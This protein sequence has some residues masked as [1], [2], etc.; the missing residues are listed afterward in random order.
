MSKEPT[1][2]TAIQLINWITDRAINGIPPLCSAENLALVIKIDASYPD[3][4]E[5]IEALINWETYKNFTTGFITGLRK[6][7][8]RSRSQF[9][10]LSEHHG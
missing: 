2:N 3:D 6:G 8:V 5:R 4:E 9:R 1:E 7:I 10:R